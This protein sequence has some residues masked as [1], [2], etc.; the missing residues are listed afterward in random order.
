MKKLAGFA[1]HNTRKK[2][3]FTRLNAAVLTAELPGAALWAAKFELFNL[4]GDFD[5]NLFFGSNRNRSGLTSKE[6]NNNYQANRAPEEPH[7]FHYRYLTNR[8]LIRSAYYSTKIRTLPGENLPDF[9]YPL[10]QAAQ[11]NLKLK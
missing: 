1:G 6:Q 5:L 11:I 10:V 3:L 4:L 2:A 8:I 7:A 9:N